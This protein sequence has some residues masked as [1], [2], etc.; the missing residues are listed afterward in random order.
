MEGH[1]KILVTGATGTVGRHLVEQLH[2]AGY[3]V[4]ALTRN[5][6]K[7][8]FPDGVEVVVGDLTSPSIIA[9]VLEGVE[10]LHLITFGGDD[11]APLQ[12]GQE[13][14]EMAEKAGVKRV[15]VLMGGEKGEL[16]KA[17]E[18]S[19]MAWTFLQPVEFM[20]GALDWVKSICAEGV[21]RQG[22]IHR[23]SAMVHEADIAAV[24][25]VALTEDG[26]GGKTYTI[27]GGEVLTP[28]EM[29]RMIGEAM[30]REVRLIELT[31]AEAR[32]QWRT[33]GFPD[34]VIEFFVW[35]HGNTPPIGYT[36]VN[37]VE[38]VTGRQPRTFAQWA[39]ENAAKF[40]Q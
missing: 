20:S 39:A 18:S 6:A 15:T 7:A 10:A 34:E 28:P 24:A 5:Q 27:T 4:R 3:Q 11:Y 33:E 8:N 25:A 21:V 12:T 9:P 30:G 13:I 1:M 17:V 23:K 37:T 29:V 36:V 19:S 35:A 14:M 26:H 22:F 38:Q 40:R 31:E 2:R 16:E 32:E